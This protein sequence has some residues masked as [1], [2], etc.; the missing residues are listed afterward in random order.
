MELPDL[1]G[2]NMCDAPLAIIEP[3]KKEVYL[4]P[5]DHWVSQ[6]PFLGKSWMDNRSMNNIP[7][8]VIDLHA[9]AKQLDIIDS[10]KK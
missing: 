1:I 4:I 7:F 5:E 6:N 8:M 10:E 9:L 2:I 3:K